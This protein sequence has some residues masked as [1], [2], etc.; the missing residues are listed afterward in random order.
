MLNSSIHS[1]RNRKFKSLLLRTFQNSDTTSKTMSTYHDFSLP[2]IHTTYPLIPIIFLFLSWPT[3]KKRTGSDTVA[4]G[5]ASHENN[6]MFAS[7]RAM[8]SCTHQS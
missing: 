6:D 8:E 2:T 1:N 5:D 4:R 3:R 7:A